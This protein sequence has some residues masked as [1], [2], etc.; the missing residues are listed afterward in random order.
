[1]AVVPLISCFVPLLLGWNAVVGEGGPSEGKE[2]RGVKHVTTVYVCSV[3][4]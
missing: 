4:S 2:R 1:M 3:T